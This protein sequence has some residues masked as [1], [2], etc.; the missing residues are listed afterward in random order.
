MNALITAILIAV[1][2]AL[3]GIGVAEDSFFIALAGLGVGA[4]GLM[5]VGRE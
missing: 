1:A 5:N 4:L 3:I 2:A